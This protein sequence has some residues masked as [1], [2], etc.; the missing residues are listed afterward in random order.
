MVPLERPHAPAGQ[1][2]WGTVPDT[3]LCV[4]RQVTLASA[5]VPI[6]PNKVEAWLAIGRVTVGLWRVDDALAWARG[7]RADVVW[8]PSETLLALRK[9]S[10]P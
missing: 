7:G 9:A 10:G 5:N 6:K 3:P 2:L 1:K 8:R 4:K